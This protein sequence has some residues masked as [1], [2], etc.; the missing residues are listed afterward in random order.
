MDKYK[1]NC[2]SP[3]IEPHTC[4]L[5]L[6]LFLS[7]FEKI[8][9]DIFFLVKKAILETSTEILRKFVFLTM[10]EKEKILRKFGLV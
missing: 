6:L 9:R 1:Q 3:Q 7:I 8:Y 2:F 10:F 5:C 4:K